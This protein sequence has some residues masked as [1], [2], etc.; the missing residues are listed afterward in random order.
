M[1][2]NNDGWSYNR[3]DK[4]EAA[5]R[6]EEIEE[7]TEEEE[8]LEEGKS[9]RPLGVMHHFARGVKQERGAK[10]DE[11]GKYLRQQ[12][13]KKQNEKEA[14]LDAHREKQRNELGLGEGYNKMQK[15]G[16]V[17]GMHR[18]ADTGK[19][20][21]KAEVGKTYYPNMP[22]KKTSVALRK[23]KE[24]GKLKEQLEATGLFTAEEIEALVESNCGDR[25]YPKGMQKGGRVGYQKGG[26]V[27]CDKCE[28][29]G[30][31][32]CDNK[33]THKKEEVKEAAKPD[34]LDMD[35]DGDKKEPMKKAIK[36]KGSKKCD[37]CGSEDCDCD[38]KKKESKKDD[39]KPAF[40]QKEGNCYQEGGKVKGASPMPGNMTT[41]TLSNKYKAKSKEVK[42]ALINSIMGDGLANN[43]VSA[44]I[45]VEHMSDEWVEA[46]LDD[47]AD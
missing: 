29:K 9:E 1:S 30:C 17:K 19:V 44:E 37:D 10:K 35:G 13:T 26:E 31:D 21:D 12:H 23:E 45:I 42:E 4:Y 16:E 34:F 46:I 5:L 7:T 28:G 39:K 40:L 32:H 22:K 41:S 6:G 27:K 20:V 24:A 33:G 2:G 18:E 11:G 8:T 38:D 15:G 25:A 43:P 47:L 3:F 14:V 36:E